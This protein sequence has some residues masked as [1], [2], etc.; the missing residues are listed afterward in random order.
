M[1]RKQYL[2]TFKARVIQELLK[3]EKTHSYLLR[4]ISSAYPNHIWGID[5]TYI[6]LQAGWMML[7]N[8]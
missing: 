2:A 7:F 3:E 6:R 5:I 1:M 8:Y 4:H